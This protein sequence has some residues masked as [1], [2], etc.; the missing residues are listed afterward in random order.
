[1]T[2]NILEGITRRTI[3][4]LA[5]V[6]LDLTVVERP[7]DRTELYIADEAFSVHGAGG[8]HRQH[9]QPQ[10]GHVLAGLITSRI[11]QPN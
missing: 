5:R 7:I 6:E 11:S 10:G 2:D 9:R 3:M 1:M 8:G 4:E